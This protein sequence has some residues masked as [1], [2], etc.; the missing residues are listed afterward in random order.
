MGTHDDTRASAPKGTPRWVA[1]GFLGAF[2][3]TIV[4]V[5]LTGLFVRGPRSAPSDETRGEAAVEP[6]ASAAEARAAHEA[7][8]AG[9]ET[10]VAEEAGAAG[11]DADEAD[12]GQ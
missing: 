5:I 4:T 2:A 8:A 6:R 11:D 10:P 9:R 12:A 1:F 3:A 7:G